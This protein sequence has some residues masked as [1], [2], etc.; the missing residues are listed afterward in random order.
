MRCPCVVRV[1]EEGHSTYYVLCTLEAHD[2]NEL[3]HLLRY[4]G[5]VKT[6]QNC[7]CRGDNLVDCVYRCGDGRVVG[8]EFKSDFKP[9]SKKV[10]CGL[11][12]SSIVVVVVGRRTLPT[13]H[14]QRPVGLDEF[15]VVESPLE[16]CDEEVAESRFCGND[17]RGQS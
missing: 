6:C 11:G 14:F 12:A 1:Y 4:G 10:G 17:V 5:S 7:G 13:R 16:L 2:A 3:D 9:Q 15:V 8:V